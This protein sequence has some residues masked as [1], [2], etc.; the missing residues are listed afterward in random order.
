VT[1]DESYAK[2]HPPVQPGRYVM[3]AVSDTGTGIERSILPRIFD[4]FFTTK[5]VGKGTGLGLSIVYGIVKQSGGYIWVYSEPGHGTT[6]KLYFPVTTGSPDRM[7]ARAERTSC[8]AG[9]LVLVVDDEANIRSNVRDCLQQ[10]GYE[11]LV[12]DSGQ[13]ALR[14]CEERQGKIDLLLTDLVMA[15]LN[16]HEIANDLACRYQRIPV[17]FMSGYTEDNA[18]RREILLQGRT[19]L[20]KPFSVAD[21]A[22]AVHNALSLKSTAQ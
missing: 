14:I 17:L 8:P 6:F 1:L 21:L 15:G 7:E 11:V 19:F 9:Q 10:L 20:Q 5:E 4:P 18:A 22:S 13:A 2:D 16:G 3:M 12:A